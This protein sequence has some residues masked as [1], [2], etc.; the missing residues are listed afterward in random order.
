MDNNNSELLAKVEAK[1]GKGVATKSFLRQEAIL[2]NNQNSYSFDFDANKPSQA[3]ERRLAVQDAFFANKIGLFLLK[4][5]DTT[6]G[7]G[8]PR[9]FADPDVFTAVAGFTLAHLETIYNGSVKAEIGK[10]TVFEALPTI[11]F[12]KVPTEFQEGNGVLD[13]EPALILYGNEKNRLTLTIPVFSGI[14]IENPTAGINH[15]VAIILFG[16]LVTGVVR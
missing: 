6:I 13:I 8:V 15:K 1:Y 2:K 7:S 10:Q 16:F 5:T 3:S 12:R 9:T 11:Q 14:Q 4:E